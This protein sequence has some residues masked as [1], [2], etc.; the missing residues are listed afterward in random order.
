MA[1]YF[2]GIVA[3]EEI[4]RRVM[5]WKN[6]MLQHFGCKVALRSPAHITLVPPF[7][8][9]ELRE[10]RLENDIRRFSSAQIPFSIK[11]GNFSSFPPRV[12]FVRIESSAQ[13]NSLQKNIEDY[14]A[15]LNYPVKKPDR[16]FH[17][18]ITIANRDLRKQ[19]YQKAFNYFKTI[20][21]AADF[22]ASHIDILVSKPEGWKIVA[23][24]PMQTFDF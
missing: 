11:L 13:L 5:E 14:L 12:I 6:Y 23:H 16:P 2:I 24:V 4:N 1:L 7:N 15:G 20:S 3:P 22:I 9:D 19:D 21:F 8:L 10:S 18:H 17:P